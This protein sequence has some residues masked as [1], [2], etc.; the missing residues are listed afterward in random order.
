MYFKLCNNTYTKELHFTKILKKPKVSIVSAVYNRGKFLS[1]FLNS[2]YFQN[3][4]HIEILLIDDF[5]TD[6]SISLIKKYQ[7]IDKRIVL[8][9]NKKNVGTFKS[10]NLGI[11]ASS[12]EYVILP[13]PDDILSRNSLKILYSIA[14]KYNYEMLKFNLYVGN[15]KIYLSNLMNKIPNKPVF[16][17][18]IQ[19][20][21]YYAT[22]KLSNFDTDIANKFIKRQALIKALNLLGKDYLNIYMTTYEDQLLNYILHRTVQSFYFL[23]IIGYFYII[24]PQSITIKGFNSNDIKNIFIN[25]NII[26]DFSKNNIFEKNMFNNFFGNN[27]IRKSFINKTDSMKNDSKFYINS[28]DKFIHNDFVSNKNRNYMIQFRQKLIGLL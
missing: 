8:I 10:R 11:L 12:G 27:V 17:P 1:R 28:L 19:T 4:K 15:N 9:R 14:K 23:K 25:L 18:K 13:D 24:N 3:F 21:L 5:S 7:I 6:D 16:Q 26:F 22:G 2:I 20:F